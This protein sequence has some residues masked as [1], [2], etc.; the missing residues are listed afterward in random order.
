MINYELLNL[1]LSAF[2]AI[3]TCGATIFAVFFWLHDNKIKLN[4]RVLHGEAAYTNPQI[5]NGYFVLVV[6]NCSNWPITLETVGLKSFYKKTIWKKFFSFLMFESTSHDTLP[7]KLE[8]G[9]SY[10]YVVPMDEMI[11]KFKRHKSSE[12]IVSL[13]GFVCV[14]TAKNDLKFKIKKDLQNA[15]M[16]KS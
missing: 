16:C 2:T 7:K 1:I 13:E 11:N 10:R 3:G 4:F 8:Y 5:E 15:M 6:T 14:S 12:E 9:Q